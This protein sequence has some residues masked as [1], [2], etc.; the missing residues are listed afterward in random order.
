MSGLWP[1]FI[2]TELQ[3]HLSAYEACSA[4]A[5]THAHTRTHTYYNQDTQ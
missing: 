4:T 5:H 1:S 2:A 3:Q